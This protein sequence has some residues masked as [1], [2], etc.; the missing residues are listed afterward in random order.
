MTT[1]FPG[2]NDPRKNHMEVAMSHSSLASEV[3]HPHFCNILL[4]TQVDY[5]VW[6]RLEYQVP[7][8]TGGLLQVWLPQ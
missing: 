5:S 4:I 2:R 3:T 1:G 6:E 7:R 8:I